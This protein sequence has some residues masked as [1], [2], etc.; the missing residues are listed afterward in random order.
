MCTARVFSR[1][2]YKRQGSFRFTNWSKQCSAGVRL[3]T[4]LAFLQDVHEVLHILHNAICCF[5]L[6]VRFTPSSSGQRPST[7]QPGSQWLDVSISELKSLSG[8]CASLPPWVLEL[9]RLLF[10]YICPCKGNARYLL[11]KMTRLPETVYPYG[12]MQPIVTY[13]TWT[14]KQVSSKFPLLISSPRPFQRDKGCKVKI[15]SWCVQSTS[16][17]YCAGQ[18]ESAKGLGKGRKKRSHSGP[19]RHIGQ[20]LSRAREQPIASTHTISDQALWLR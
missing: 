1:C 9:Y 2:I 7:A 11:N 5:C 8:T 10:L 16:Q 17:K 13:A 6:A 14:Y 15:C 12:S 20:G 3:L 4:V 19:C 18:D